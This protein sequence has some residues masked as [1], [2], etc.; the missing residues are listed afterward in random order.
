VP[1]ERI[2]EEYRGV[3]FRQ[4]A[5]KLRW[6][7]GDGFAHQTESVRPRNKATLRFEDPEGTFITFED[8][9]RV[10][11]AQLIRTGALAIEA[12][13]PPTPPV[14]PVASDPE[15]APLPAPPPAALKLTEGGD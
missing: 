15:P 2:A 6:P 11:V 3:R 13:A 5:P 12:P 7:V 1:D 9:A 8:D 10:N 14:P 4:L